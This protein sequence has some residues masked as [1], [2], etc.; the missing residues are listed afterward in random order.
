[1]MFQMACTYAHT[2]ESPYKPGYEILLSHLK[3]PLSWCADFTWTDTDSC[4][5]YEFPQTY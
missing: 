5:D 4:D 1:M 2:K 3:V